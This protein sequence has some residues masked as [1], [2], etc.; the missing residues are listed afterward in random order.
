M[1]AYVVLNVDIRDAAGS[2]EYKRAGPR[3]VAVA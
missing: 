3:M 1:A 2:E